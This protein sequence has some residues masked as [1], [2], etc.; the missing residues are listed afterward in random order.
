MLNPNPNPNPNGAPRATP[1]RRLDVG[2]SAAL[3]ALPAAAL[4]LLGNATMCDRLLYEHAMEL[5]DLAE[6]SRDYDTP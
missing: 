5:F 4:E 2:A 6:G 1:R 3:S